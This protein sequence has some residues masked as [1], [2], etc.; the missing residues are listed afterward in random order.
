MAPLCLEL[1]SGP[2]QCIFGLTS[3]PSPHDLSKK[4]VKRR[5]HK[6]NKELNQQCILSR[7]IDL[8]VPS[9]GLKLSSTHQS[10]WTIDPERRM[11]F[12]MRLMIHKRTMSYASMIQIHIAPN[13]LKGILF[14]TPIS[15]GEDGSRS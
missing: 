4:F 2:S 3:L 11:I 13:H 6:P 9:E 10:R 12:S 8:L 1:L 5:N 15:N 14:Q 7:P